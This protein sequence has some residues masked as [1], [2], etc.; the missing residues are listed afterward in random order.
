MARGLFWFF[1]ARVAW[2]SVLFFTASLMGQ[3]SGAPPDSTVS[4]EYSDA[5]LVVYLQRNIVADEQRLEHLAD[6]AEELSALFDD[7]S[8]NARQSLKVEDAEAEGQG[9]DG[10]SQNVNRIGDRAS[11][12]KLEIILQ[13]RQASERQE[14]VVRQKLNQEQE[15]L[16]MVLLGE[17]P[18][19]LRGEQER[20]RAQPSEEQEGDSKISGGLSPVGMLVPSGEKQSD[21]QSKEAESEEETRGVL[22]IKEVKA[23]ND[24]SRR[25]NESTSLSHQ[26]SMVDRLIALEEADLALA[27]VLL[28]SSERGSELVT[29]AI[30]NREGEMAN[31][32]EESGEEGRG[33]EAEIETLN[34][35][36]ERVGEV[37][38]EDEEL[39]QS[40]S[41]RL[42]S[43]ASF[44]AP[45]LDLV[46]DAEMAV[47]KARIRLTLVQ[48]PLAPHNIKKWF[49]SSAPKLVVIVV[50]FV[51]IWFVVQSFARRL[52]LR[53]VRK[54]GYGSETERMERVDT[55]VRVFKNGATILIFGLGL[56]AILPEFGV[57]LTVL[58]GGA[59]VI[60]LAVAFGA[61]A[62][63]KDYF[64][65]IMILLENQYRVGNVIRLNNITG[66][67]EDVSLRVTMLRDL[68]GI[69]HFVPHGQITL[70]SNLSH[71][72]SRAVF[73]IGVAY[74]ENVDHVI[75]VLM[76]LAGELRNDFDFGPYIVEDAEM[77][78][79]D[80]LSDSAVIIRF[81]IKTRPLKQFLIRR[82]MLR[83]IKNRFDELGIE[84]PFPHRTIY[85]REYVEHPGPDAE[86][87]TPDK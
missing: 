20:E 59:A 77:L 28:K 9:E 4:D 21:N 27:E 66:L 57:D 65:G 83:R 37:L 32:S 43:M 15:L 84:I 29:E 73:D 41:N 86:S 2:A 63:V 76:K 58:L 80:K 42:E 46:S 67:V 33:F 36:M 71:G 12:A 34:A 61:Q 11:R 44:R 72:W 51:L 22:S 45:L 85:N 7:I 60:S 64:S 5:D 53:T 19:V 62:L 24:L 48:S 55:I 26:L 25:L 18:A 56:I 49:V 35:L 40:L 52:F 82:E 87:E 10:S 38:Q 74:K 81:I 3:D 75:D 6:S 13:R 47:E 79:V 69:A 31:L 39:V 70:V 23:R 17:E 8:E 14:R 50:I 1:D 54:S 78:G 30:A 68:D 16:E